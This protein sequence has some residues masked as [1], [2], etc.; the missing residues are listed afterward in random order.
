MPPSIR[1]ATAADA[2]NLAALAIQVWLHTYATGG[3][4]SALSGYVLSEY[5][6]AHFLGLLADPGHLLLLAEVDHH[7]VGYA[8]LAFASPCATEPGLRTELATLYIQEHFTG[9]GIGGRLM[10]ACARH[11]RERCGS[12]DFW[13]S[14]YHLNE[15]AITFYRKH[16]LEERGSFF[17]EFGGERHKNFIFLKRYSP[18]RTS[19]SDGPRF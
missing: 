17:F 7:L 19:G 11:A 15:R 10:S 8:D 9:Q 12:P 3:I 4:R 16:G 6:E 13:L 1:Q 18:P 5:T 14:V 2:L